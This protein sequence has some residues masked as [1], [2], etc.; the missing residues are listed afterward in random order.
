MEAAVGAQQRAD[1]ALVEANQAEEERA[2]V[3]AMRRQC[4][5]KLSVIRALVASRAAD[6][7]F[8]TMS[9]AG[10]SR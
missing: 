6:R 7:A 9:T 2:H 10:N 1:P 4:C 5:S 3:V 8:T